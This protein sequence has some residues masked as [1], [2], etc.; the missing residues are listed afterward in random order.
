M[1]VT[2][3]ITGDAETLDSSVLPASILDSE[4]I[5]LADSDILVSAVDL[6]GAS[7]NTTSS[8]TSSA[9]GVSVVVIVASVLGGIALAAVT[10]LA[11]YHIIRARNIASGAAVADKKSFHDPAH[12]TAPDMPHHHD[13]SHRGG[14]I[15]PGPMAPRGPLS[16]CMVPGDAQGGYYNRI[17]Q[18]DLSNQCI[19]TGMK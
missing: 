13:A 4:V 3:G 15:L 9:N 18:M 8:D 12:P 2:V 5:P 14:F 11:V 17:L 19:V 16:I 7:K 1:A 10:G 6:S